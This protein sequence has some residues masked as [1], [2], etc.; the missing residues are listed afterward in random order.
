M[1]WWSWM[2]RSSFFECWVLSQLYHS[3]FTFIKRLFSSFSLS[4]IRVVLSAFLTLLIFL[5]AILI[6][7]W[8]HPAQHFPYES[9]LDCKEIQ[10]VHPEGNQSWMFIGGTDVEA[11]TPILW[12]PYA[13]RWL[14]WKDSDAGKDWRQEE[15]GM[16]EDEMVG[17]YHWLDGHEFEW[18]TPRVGDGQGSLVCCSPWVHKESYM[19]EWLN[20]TE[21]NAEYK[22]NKQGDSIQ[23]WCTPS[24]FWTSPLFHVP[25]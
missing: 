14:I 23:L 6:P 5:P 21:L 4:A 12:L 11:E 19:T 17:W 24:Q 1:K 20:W 8:L 15:K 18:T 16:A 25:F 9:P 3:S 13:K 2:P 7:A 10:P 22:L